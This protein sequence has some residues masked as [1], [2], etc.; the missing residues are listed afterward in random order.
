MAKQAKQR[1]FIHYVLGKMLLLFF[2]CHPGTLATCDGQAYLRNRY[3]NRDLVTTESEMADHRRHY[4]PRD[5]SEFTMKIG[6]PDEIL[7]GDV[8]NYTPDWAPSL[9]ERFHN[10]V[11]AWLRKGS[12][13]ASKQQ[14]AAAAVAAQAVIPGMAFVPSSASRGVMDVYQRSAND[15]E[16]ARWTSL[17]EIGT[18]PRLVARS[19][20]LPARTRR[21]VCGGGGDGSGGGRSARGRDTSMLLGRFRRGGFPLRRGSG[22]AESKAEGSKGASSDGADVEGQM[23]AAAAAAAAAAED[24]RYSEP[25]AATS[26]TLEDPER[27]PPSM[28][29]SIFGGAADAYDNA[30]SFVGSTLIRSEIGR[31]YMN[32]YDSGP[33]SIRRS[34]GGP[35]DFSTGSTYDLV[36]FSNIDPFEASARRVGGASNRL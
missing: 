16:K 22:E 12:A 10:T 23:M 32:G 30:L 8:D 33:T 7:H 24:T 2:L 34:G 14:A 17:A 36:G 1:V 29:S 5:A 15:R 31:K 13:L 11:K 21:S 25:V 9:E 18:N 20:R 4:T 35:A 27:T 19:N 6:V 26:E 3:A 28:L